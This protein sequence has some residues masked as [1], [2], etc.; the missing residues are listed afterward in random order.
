MTKSGDKDECEKKNIE[1]LIEALEEFKKIDPSMSL[2]SILAFLYYHD[3]YNRSGNRS[4]VEERL[5]MSGATASRA[6]FYWLNSRRH[7]KKCEYARA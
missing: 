1:K 6:T 4:L 2:P 5:N 7:A 3:V